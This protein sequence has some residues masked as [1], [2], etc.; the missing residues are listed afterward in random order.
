MRLH[1]WL[2]TVALAGAVAAV[3]PAQA[4]TDPEQNYQGI[5]YACTGI[6]L[7][8]RADPR[9]G[10]YPAKLVFA[11]RTGGYLGDIRVAIDDA[12]GNRV[13][14]AHCLSPWLVVNL[15]PGSYRIDATARD[16]YTQSMNLVVRSQGQVER[17]VTFPQ[18][19]N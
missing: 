17:L 9:W 5:S 4:V 3:A 18:I 6:G 11:E 8:S 12:A 10:A 16:T 7:E 1:I 2:S 14:E 13:F 15:P 19:T